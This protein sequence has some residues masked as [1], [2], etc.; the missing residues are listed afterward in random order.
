MVNCRYLSNSLTSTNCGCNTTI[1]EMPIY[2]AKQHSTYPPFKVDVTDC[3]GEP[4]DLKD[5]VV[6]AAM[7]TNARLKTA[8]TITDDLIR[9][10][11][12]VGYNS[13]GPSSILHVSNG[14]DFERM[15]IVGFD[16]VNKVIQVNRG[17]CDTTIRPWTKGTTV[18]ILRFFNSPASSELTYH[19]RENVDGTVTQNV[20]QR[21]TLIYEWKPEDVCFVGKYY[22]EFK[23]LKMAI[24][25]NLNAFDISTIS[26]TPISEI[27]YHCELGLG[28][29]WARRFPNDKEGF[30]IE[31]TSSPTAEC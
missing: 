10:A 29:E 23:V 28:V 20:L 15:T 13:V 7:W 5:L 14:R 3:N 2:V 31:V 16:D 9:F 24:L 26:I 25:N 22:F 27:N 8:I 17:A 30:V 21:S 12:N 6:E 1:A 19:N 18:K 11:D 4:Y